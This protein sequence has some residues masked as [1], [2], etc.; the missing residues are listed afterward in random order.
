MLVDMLFPPLASILVART[1]G[2]TKLGSFS[3][4]SWLA[5]TASALGYSG[6]TAAARKFMADYAGQR[7]PAVFKAILF[8]I[9][10]GQV[11][12]LSLITGVGLIWARWWLP[13]EDWWFASLT[14]L[15][16]VPAGLM[17]M[18]TA[19]NSSVQ[20]LRPNA[21][22]SIA[23]GLVHSVGLV[24]TA[25]LGWGLVG[26]A[27]AGLISRTCDCVVRWLLT[28]RRMPRYL[29][30][31]REDATCTAR[32]LALPPGLGRQIW[33]FVGESSILTLLT[34]VVWS[35]SEMIFL[36]RYSA[37]EQVAYFSVAFSLS[38]IPG[39]LVGPFSRAAA[40]TV[41]GERGR[42]QQAGLHVA[43]V[44]WRYL[45]LLVLPAC[46]G[47]AVLAG[48]LLRVLYGARYFDAVPVLVMAGALSMFASLAHP[49]TTLVTAA[50][51]QRRLVL[52]GIVAAVATLT[53]D[54]LLVRPYGAMGGA[55]ANGLG[56]AISTATVLLVARRY[57]FRSRPTFVLRVTGAALVMAMAVLA[58]VAILPDLA[59]IVVGPA[60][61]AL[62]YG[63]SLRVGRVIDAEDVERL[64][65]AQQVLPPPL[66]A[67]FR[68]VLQLF[69]HSA[70]G[71]D[72][73]P[74]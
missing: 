28:L 56:Q 37:I 52:A 14:M 29:E 17:A 43:H 50:G 27:A 68:R 15:A 69:A 73:V 10:I 16:I 1:L 45:V 55:L 22:A 2:P 71:E 47:L 40:V 8:W 18:A 23:S 62:A 44:Y 24:L 5:A 39:Q 11:V 61:G 72:P 46:L 33:S 67:P 35:R 74:M 26:L 53:L 32:S 9:L 25:L 6:G 51:G 58:V 36:K 19:V 65:K 7:K 60:V 63:A 20:E 42:D 54:Y 4:I 3:Y 31:M 30:A 57:S 41:F 59:G 49:A 38:L 70:K 13:A 12:A 48:P 64:L 66:R 34:L 21:I